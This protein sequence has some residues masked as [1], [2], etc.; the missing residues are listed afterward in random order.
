[1]LSTLKGKKRE[2]QS[3]LTGFNFIVKKSK[4]DT[5][6]QVHTSN[7][8][9]T[10]S[11]DNA[12]QPDSESDEPSSKTSEIPQDLSALGKPRRVPAKNC[13]SRENDG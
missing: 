7:D 1:M 2:H 6:D 5:T 4:I 8:N 9:E 3:T 10:A 11:S 12:T 13:V